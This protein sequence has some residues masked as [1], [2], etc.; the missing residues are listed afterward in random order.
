MAGHSSHH[1]HEEGVIT[2]KMIVEDVLHVCPQAEAVFKKH[3]GENVF[4]VPGLKTEAI[5]FLAAMHD[6]HE[7][8]LLEELNQ[9][10]KK[11]PHKTG[12]F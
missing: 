9:V 11:A 8:I 10:C 6:Y 1:H 2:G 5:E 4:K 7:Y 12:H 3:L